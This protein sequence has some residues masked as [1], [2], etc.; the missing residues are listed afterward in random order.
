M[1]HYAADRSS[2]RDNYLGKIIRRP[3]SGFSDTPSL[4]LHPRAEVYDNGAAKTFLNDFDTLV[5]DS[6]ARLCAVCGEQPACRLTRL[7]K[8]KTLLVDIIHL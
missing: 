6:L 3:E 4:H 1:A 5:V 8:V 2:F 7:T